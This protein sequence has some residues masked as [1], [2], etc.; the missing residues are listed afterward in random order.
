MTSN[1]TDMANAIRA[2]SMDAVQRANSGH[3]GMPMGMAE[4]GTAL[5]RRHLSHN[6][7]NPDWINRDR[8]VLS[9]G[10]GSM[11]IYALLHLS[12]YDLSI[13]DL[14]AFRSLHSKTP[15]HPERG[16]TP[17]VETTTGPL[18][19]G[20]ANA[21][22][23]AIAEKALAAEYNRDG[24]HVVDHYTYVFLG[25][26]CLMEGISHE[27]CSLAGTLG[28][29]KLIVL[30]DDNNISIDGHVDGW[31]TDDT[32]RRFAS[33]G[34]QVIADVDG[35]DVD[36]V[37]RAI[38]EGRADASRPT[39]ICCKTTI[40]KGAPN[41]ANSH[42]SHGSPLGDAEI[43]ATR[44]A[45]GWPHEPFEIPR[46]IAEAWDMRS[47]G[48][49]REAEWT[50]RF[51]DYR[52]AFP[53]LAVSLERRMAGDLP[54]D[55]ETQAE[56]FIARIG[57]ETA[58]VATRKTSLDAIT[59]FSP[60]LPELIGGSADLAS[61]NLTN[62]SGMDPI[63][64]EQG[65]NYIYYGVREFGMAAIMNGLAAHGG[66]RPFGATYLTFSDYSRNAIRM[67]ALMKLGTIH[68]LTHDSI[69][70]GQDGPT[71]QPI[72][73]LASLRLM[74]NL[75]LWRPCDAV[76]AAVAWTVAI[77]NRAKPTVLALSRQ[78]L[79]R[80]D[81]T[82]E[83]VCEIRRGGYV[84]RREEGALAAILLATGSEV[85]IAT[86]AAARLAERNVHVRVVSMPSTGRFDSQP[87]EYR[88]SVLPASVPVVSIE[89]GATGGWHKY[90]GPNGRCIGIDS[91][92]ESAAPDALF[93]YFRLTPEAV[94]QAV[95][96][97]GS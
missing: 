47:E 24:H 59:H 1:T 29:G 50:E 15:G 72:E 69:A 68:V 11:L 87:A 41:K 9:N 54:V 67:A 78:G 13:D 57:A 36:A 12:G 14:K 38:A 71:H 20:I 16:Y 84:L 66:M 8:F 2:L 42:D 65:G 63:T 46:E 4:I 85:E 22:G 86:A 58:S 44:A 30:Y 89:A 62:W 70:L 79:T 19:Q 27:V 45:I 93:D 80:Q 17:G 95:E 92:G 77:E 48:E 52:R 23:M 56:A 60:L 21:V 97:L 82:P 88:D 64:A 33:Y 26:G 43:A 32:P 35:H 39:L 91:F 37:D 55:F 94:I 51:A 25:D 31:F 6:P 83:T 75:D 34:W 74:P 18:G 53:D 49:I 7:A 96:S 3:P 5:W 73:H 76:E 28:L 61:S 81:R 90:V 40:G 10:H